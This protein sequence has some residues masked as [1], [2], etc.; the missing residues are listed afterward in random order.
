[1]TFKEF[2]FAFHQKTTEY[3]A[4][5]ASSKGFSISSVLELNSMSILHGGGNA[6]GCFEYEKEGLLGGS[7]L[8]AVYLVNAKTTNDEFA[9]EAAFQGR[10]LPRFLSLLRNESP[11]QSGKTYAMKAFRET[12]P[13]AE[14][15]LRTEIHA[16]RNLN[17]KNIAQIYDSFVDRSQVHIVMELCD[18]GNLASRIPFKETEAARVV[19]KLLSAL[20]CL[21][22][23]GIVHAALNMETVLF[24]SGAA[25]AEIKIINHG[26]SRKLLSGSRLTS[27]E[28]DESLYAASPESF[29]GVYTSKGDMWSVGVITYYLL[30][31]EKPFWGKRWYERLRNADVDFE[32]GS[33]GTIS[34]EA[35]TFIRSL[36]QLNVSDRPDPATA[37]NYMWL[38]KSSL[39]LKRRFRA[40]EVEQQDEYRMREESF[41]RIA[42]NVSQAQ[43]SRLLCKPFSHTSIRSRLWP[44]D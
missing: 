33:W 12:S 3:A 21:H 19:L 24:D 26:L 1:V 42:I 23:H 13:E 40:S 39:P 25:N 22:S 8:S 38:V 37:S 16:I 43:E 11:L 36:L 41:K 9:E 17:H 35:K 30:S 32:S 34:K 31:G 28:E 10:K 5:I 20:K 27:E 6:T 7:E 14:F 4:K 44:T 2:L 18:G 29:R 15:D